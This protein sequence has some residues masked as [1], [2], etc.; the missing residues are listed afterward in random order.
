MQD[1]S[2]FRNLSDPSLNHAIRDIT[3]A[4][5]CARGFDPKGED[6]YADQLH[7]A[8]GER[9]RRQGKHICPT[10]ERPL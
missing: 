2:Y 6:K 9:N 10:C 5:E 3:E 7:A 4:Y 8:I 1:A